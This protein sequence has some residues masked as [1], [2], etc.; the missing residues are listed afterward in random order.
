M[1][2]AEGSVLRMHAL[3]PGKGFVPPYKPPSRHGG[4]CS[5]CHEPI[6]KVVF[7][8]KDSPGRGDYHRD[9]FLEEFI[10]KN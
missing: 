10:S 9:C 3:Q 8:K 1:S 6:G 4:N 7:T 5:K 2:G